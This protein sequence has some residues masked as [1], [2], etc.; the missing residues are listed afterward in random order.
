[1]RTSILIRLSTL[2]ALLCVPLIVILA[3][4]EIGRA[5]V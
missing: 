5:H 2:P 3:Q 4:G 1:M